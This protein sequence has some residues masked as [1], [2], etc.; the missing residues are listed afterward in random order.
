MDMAHTTN[1]RTFIDQRKFS[2]FQLL[3]TA[4]CALV[5]FLD[6]FDT[7][8]IGYVAPAI[9]K[10]FQ[11]S[12]ATL[13][14]VFSASLVGLMLGALLGGP[15]SDRFGRRPVLLAGLLF[16][17]LMSLLTA[18]ATSIPGFLVLRLLSR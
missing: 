14:P 17:G 6:G 5:V 8:A 13:S 3:V 7:Q 18:S 11:V 4:M 15:V 2:K 1:V 9:I 12:R 10:S 16:F